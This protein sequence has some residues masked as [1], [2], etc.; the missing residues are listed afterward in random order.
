[1]RALVASGHPAT[2]IDEDTL[3]EHLYTAGQPD[4]DLI[5]R[6]GGEHRTSNFL[7]WQGAYAELVVSEVLWPD[8]KPEDLD[9]A[10]EEFRGR[11]RRFGS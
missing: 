3:A 6:T 2:D 1:V 8:F 4:P 5:I 11:H 9:A 7:L 10:V